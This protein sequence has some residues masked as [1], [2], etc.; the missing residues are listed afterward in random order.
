MQRDLLGS[1]LVAMVE[2]P[3]HGDKLL[4]E[5]R[6]YIPEPDARDRVGLIR[7]ATLF[8]DVNEVVQVYYRVGKH[9]EAQF[10]C[11]CSDP[12]CVEKVRLTR[13]EYGD[14]R[15]HP[16]R[17]FRVPG[18][19]ALVDRIVEMKPRFTVVEKPLVP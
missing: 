13:A 10:V 8:R 12:A 16:T 1:R 2:L 18:H 5:L 17:F 9:T 19:E 4:P 15:R 6:A 3:A 14:V 11:E 7:T